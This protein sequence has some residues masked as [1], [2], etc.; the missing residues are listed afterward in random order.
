MLG[1]QSHFA[2][3]MEC[4]WCIGKKDIVGTKIDT[5]H[6]HIS[7]AMCPR[8]EFVGRLDYTTKWA[9]RQADA[10]RH[11]GRLYNQNN[12][13]C[14]KLGLCK[15]FTH[16]GFH[17]ED[18]GTFVV[19]LTGIGSSHIKCGDICDIEIKPSFVEVRSSVDGQH[20]SNHVHLSGA[21]RYV[22]P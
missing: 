18:D 22:H 6:L 2:E 3:K 15:I 16:R 14:D 13:M 17:Q 10:T 9:F 4:L 7:P 1:T 8:M 5:A 21:L 19:I 12:R 11:L 20:G